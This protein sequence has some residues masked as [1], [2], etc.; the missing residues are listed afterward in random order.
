M[1]DM[2]GPLIKQGHV[3]NLRRMVATVAGRNLEYDLVYVD[4]AMHPDASGGTVVNEREQ[5]LGY[6]LNEP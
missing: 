2:T 5:P 1:T 6:C 4:N 3:A